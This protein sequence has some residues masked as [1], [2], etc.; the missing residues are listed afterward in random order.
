MIPLLFEGV[1]KRDIHSMQYVQFPFPYVFSLLCMVVFI[2]I[3]YTHLYLSSI[4]MANPHCMHLCES[5]A[6][7]WKQHTAPG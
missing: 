4:C 2:C 3:L 5:L 6:R 7:H 1:T